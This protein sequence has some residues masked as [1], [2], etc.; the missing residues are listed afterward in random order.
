MSKELRHF[1]NPWPIR[2]LLISFYT[3]LI[4]GSISMLYFAGSRIQTSELPAGDIQLTTTYGKYL[5]G[6]PVNFSVINRFNSSIFVI[7]ECP[8]EPLGVYRFENNRWVRIH[9]KAD[10]ICNEEDRQIN[11]PAQKTVSL[12]LAP[13]KELFSQPGKYR[14]VLFVEYYNSLPYKD[15]EIVTAPQA[16][17]SAQPAASPTKA[18]ATNPKVAATTKPTTNNSA[19][20]PAVTAANTSASAPA[21]SSSSTTS[22]TPAHS[23]VTYNVL[24]SSAGNFNLTSLTIYSGDSIKFSYTGSVGDELSVRFTPTSSG[25]PAIASLKLDHDVLSGTRSFPVTANYSVKVSNRSGNTL[26]L[27]V[28]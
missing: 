6:E 11:I 21:G 24:V 17:K 1:E 8:G 27:K 26:I 12:S 28:L 10:K 2:L 3:F 23:P 20:S 4:I 5:I 16:A 13:W 14:L 9:A 7:N 25:A 18:V 19:A 15:I 22:T